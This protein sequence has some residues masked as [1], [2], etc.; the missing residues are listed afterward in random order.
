MNYR[1]SLTSLSYFYPSSRKLNPFFLHN[2]NTLYPRSTYIC[3]SD[4]YLHPRGVGRPRKNVR[5]LS[6]AR[7]LSSSPCCVVAWPTFSLLYFFRLFF[8]FH[9]IERHNTADFD[10]YEAERQRSARNNDTRGVRW[11][12]HENYKFI[13]TP[14]RRWGNL[15]LAAMSTLASLFYP[16]LYWRSIVFFSLDRF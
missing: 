6:R 7:T 3:I 9:P 15:H 11:D 13:R 16:C 14:L 2:L 4:R 1:A 8:Y 12:A 5:Y 10:L